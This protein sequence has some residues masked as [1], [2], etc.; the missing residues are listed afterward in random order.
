M[1]WGSRTIPK[2]AQRLFLVLCSGVTPVGAQGNMSGVGFALSVTACRIHTLPTV[3]SL[4][5]K[6]SFF[7]PSHHSFYRSVKNGAI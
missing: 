5:P 2:H 6:N 4:W 7:S 1:G 3:P